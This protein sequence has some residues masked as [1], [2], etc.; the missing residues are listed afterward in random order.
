MNQCKC[1]CEQTVGAEYARGHNSRG[2]NSYQHKSGKAI[3]SNGYVQ[4]RMA[5]HPRVNS[6]GYV[7]EHILIA[8][9]A[10]KRLLPFGAEIHHFNEIRSDNRNSNLIICESGTYHKLLHRRKRA[11]IATG[12]ATAMKCLIC[13]RWD[14]PEL[15]SL[16]YNNA[17]GHWY[18]YHRS[19]A[20]QKQRERRARKRAAI[21]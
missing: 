2:E 18:S 8:E 5:D 3:N 16:K 6:G 11:F 9:R 10:I 4:I 15:I 19:C 14:I 1:G 20:A 13:K 7:L 21:S 17:R 12:S